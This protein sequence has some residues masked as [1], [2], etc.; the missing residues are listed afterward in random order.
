MKIE[1]QDDKEKECLKHILFD[2]LM[3]NGDFDVLGYEP[4]CRN[5]ESPGCDWCINDVLNMQLDKYNKLMF[6]AFGGEDWL[7][8]QSVDKYLEQRSNNEV[9][10]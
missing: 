9:N 6:W 2:W 10:E 4:A 7:M 3:H 1:F 8:Q 5:L